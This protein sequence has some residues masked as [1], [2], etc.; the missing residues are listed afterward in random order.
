MTVNIKPA[1][2][3]CPRCGCADLRVVYTRHRHERIVRS[4]ECRHC[5]KRMITVERTA[6]PPKKAG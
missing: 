1:G 4:R 5:G 2:I 3:C 6:F